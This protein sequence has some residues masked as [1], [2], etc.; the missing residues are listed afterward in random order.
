MIHTL[1]IGM[2]TK[3]MEKA[4]DEE[5]KGKKERSY[6]FKQVVLLD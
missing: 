1:I 2:I 5:D 6:W 3:I 4:I